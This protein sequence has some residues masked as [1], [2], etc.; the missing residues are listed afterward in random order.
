LDKTIDYDSFYFRVIDST[1]KELGQSG[2]LKFN[3]IPIDSEFCTLNSIKI[4]SDYGENYCSADPCGV[5]T[6]QGS[7]GNGEITQIEG[8]VDCY[9]Q[10]ECSCVWDKD[11]CGDG[12]QNSITHGNCTSL[13]GEGSAP[14]SL[15]T[16]FTE[17]IDIGDNCSDGFLEYSWKSN[18]SWGYN[19]YDN[20]SDV[21]GSH[22][23]GDIIQTP[24][25]N[26]HINDIYYSECNKCEENAC[27]RQIVCPAA[28]ALSFFT[29]LDLIIALIVIF[30]LYYFLR[31]K[32]IGKKKGSKKKIHRRK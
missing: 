31:K 13:T 30:I 18:W 11:S 22:N 25:G 8:F 23:P 1:G 14:S 19:V 32:F 26:W 5:S 29:I 12:G 15:G 17:A 21:P 27:T 24:D 4:C 10:R 6:A 7:C 20:I 3:I 9:Y 28:I 2:Y 16:C